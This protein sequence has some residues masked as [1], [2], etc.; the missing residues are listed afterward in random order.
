MSS[1][2]IFILIVGLPPN[3]RALLQN[4]KAD[5]KL[6]EAVEAQLKVLPEQLAN[7]G[8]EAKI[9]FMSPG[10]FY[11]PLQA[12]AQAAPG[13]KLLLSCLVILCHHTT[14][15]QT[16]VRDAHGGEAGFFS[17]RHLD[18][19]VFDWCI[20]CLWHAENGI[21]KWKEELKS[22]PQVDGVVIGAGIRIANAMVAWLEQLIEGVRTTA[23]QARIIFNTIPGDTVEAIQRWFK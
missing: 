6:L 7:A 23:P 21:G 5:P 1:E 10:V 2:K 19:L 8:V 17:H 16:A 15:D 18:G 9:V 14:S 20:H 4:H 22:H 13:G 11:W 12:C 3:H